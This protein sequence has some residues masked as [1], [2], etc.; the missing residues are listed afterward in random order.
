MT[1]VSTGDP[2]GE[3]RIT[4]GFFSVTVTPPAVTSAPA[5]LSAR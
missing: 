5:A 2:A 3:R 4:E 1:N